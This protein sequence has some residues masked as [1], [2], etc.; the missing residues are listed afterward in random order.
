MANDLPKREVRLFVN[1]KGLKCVKCGRRRIGD[2]YIRFAYRKPSG[3]TV[4]NNCWRCVHTPAA[5]NLIVKGFPETFSR[6]KVGSWW[7]VMPI[8]EA[9][10][11]R[12]MYA[13]VKRSRR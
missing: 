11:V 5:T 12:A 9:E 1:D 13:A 3:L 4:Q 2:P 6:V 10:K 7:Q 8:E